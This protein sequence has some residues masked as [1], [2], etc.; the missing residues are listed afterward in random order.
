MPGWQIALIAAGAVLAAAVVAVLLDRAHTARCRRRGWNQPRWPAARPGPPGDPHEPYP[1]YPPFPG[2]ARHD[3]PALA[4][5]GGRTTG[6][7]PVAPV[8]PA[9]NWHQP[10]QRGSHDDRG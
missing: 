6:A 1:A 8:N 2:G 3:A 7:A 5:P 10:D 9:G 4:P